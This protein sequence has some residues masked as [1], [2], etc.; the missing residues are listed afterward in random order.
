MEKDPSGERAREREKERERVED[1]EGKRQTEP[2]PLPRPCRRPHPTYD[3]MMSFLSSS[4]ASARR[5]KEG[6]RFSRWKVALFSLPLWI[7]R[8]SGSTSIASDCPWNCGSGRAAQPRLR[9]LDPSF[10]VSP[11]PRRSSRSSYCHRFP[12]S[13]LPHFPPPPSAL[14]PL[15][16][17]RG[18]SGEGAGVPICTFLNNVTT[19]ILTTVVLLIIVVPV[20]IQGRSFPEG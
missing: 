3:T 13:A 11:P 7:S 18:V 1:D 2:R 4:A 15:G 17:S 6:N 20:N 10:L 5:R 16:D 19:V 14:S 12:R 9:G 8:R